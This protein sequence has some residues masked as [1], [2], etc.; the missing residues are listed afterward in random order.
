VQLDKAHGTDKEAD[1]DLRDEEVSKHGYRVLSLRPKDAGY[2]EEVRKLV[3]R[4]EE[5][6][7]EASEGPWGVAIE[8]RVIRSYDESDVP[9]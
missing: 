7:M 3:E 4:V 2:F 1:D 8:A 9:F 6:M 5:R